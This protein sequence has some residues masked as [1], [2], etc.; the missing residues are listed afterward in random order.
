MDV[1]NLVEFI[2]L[3]L[4]LFLVV[5]FYY[6]GRTVPPEWKHAVKNKEVTPELKK[7]LALYPDKQ[8]FFILWLQ[9]RRI[10]KENIP[11]DFAELGVYKGESARIIHRMAPHRKFHLF[12]TFEGFRDADL[13]EESGEAATYTPAHFADTSVETA[14]QKTG[15]GDKLVFHP[16]YFP[17]TA[18]EVENGKFAFVNLDVDLSKPT[19]AA[20]EFFYSRLSPGGVILVHDYNHKWPMLMKAVDEFA[21]EIPEE[22]VMFPDKDS[23]VMIGKNRA[24]PE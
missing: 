10:E 11:G 3:A 6:T 15:A 8:R 14:R 21:A 12:D 24:H 1:I 5:R 4:L 22:P 13:M 17:E 16:G 9:I 23:T 19:K 2:L 20:L 18:A 7:S